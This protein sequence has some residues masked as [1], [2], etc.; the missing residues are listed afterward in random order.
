MTGRGKRSF[1]TGP[2]KV[3]PQNILPPVTLQCR[4]RAIKSIVIRGKVAKKVNGMNSSFQVFFP[5]D[6]LPAEQGQARITLHVDDPEKPPI[7]S[8]PNGKPNIKVVK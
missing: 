1:N 6:V 4:V 3:I 5:L 7:W 8:S 2:G